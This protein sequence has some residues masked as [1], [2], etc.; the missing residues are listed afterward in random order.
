MPA[1]VHFRILRAVNRVHT[2]EW[3]KYPPADPVLAVLG[4]WRGDG[5]VECM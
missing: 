4:C 2:A 1:A 3:S 5:I